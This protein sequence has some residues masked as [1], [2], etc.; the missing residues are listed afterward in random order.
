MKR[1]LEILK[2]DTDFKEVV[3]T[4]ELTCLRGHVSYTNFAVNVMY[5]NLFLGHADLFSYLDKAKMSSN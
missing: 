2:M 1:G 5:C 4:I 3:N